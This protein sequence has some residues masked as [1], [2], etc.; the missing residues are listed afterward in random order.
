MVIGNWLLRFGYFALL[1]NLRYGIMNGSKYV[2]L[3]SI[4]FESLYPGREFRNAVPYK[5]KGR[6]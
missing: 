5:T 4:R 2:K 3:H 1:R 6:I